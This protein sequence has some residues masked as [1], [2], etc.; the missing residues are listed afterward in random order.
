MNRFAPALAL[1]LFVPACLDEA[2]DPDDVSTLTAASTLLDM[3]ATS[4]ANAYSS[5]SFGTDS[6]IR[7]SDRVNP[8]GTNNCDCKLHQWYAYNYN[9]ATADAYVPTCRAWTLVDFTVGGQQLGYKLGAEVGEWGSVVDQTMCSNSELEVEV[10]AWGSG[11]YSTIWS[12]SAPP[13]W[14]N[15]AC[16]GPSLMSPQGYVLSGSYRVRAR[17]RRGLFKFNHGYETVTVRGIPAT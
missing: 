16:R 4:G 14:I 17:A 8:G 7:P 10:Q 12:Q 15:G 9:D 1:A 13:S 6:F 11:G 2:G 5:I 3:C